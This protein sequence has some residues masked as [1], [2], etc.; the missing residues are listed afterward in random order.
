MAYEIERKFLLINE[1][2][3]DEVENSFTLR[4]GYLSTNPDATVRIR[5]KNEQ[6]TLTIKSKNIGIR[7]NEFEYQIPTEEAQQLLALCEGPLIQK[8]RYTIY[9]GSHTW[10]ID[11]FS[12]D[13]TGL[14]LAEIELTHEDD[15]FEKPTWVGD[16]VSGDV[17]YYNSNLVA[18]PFINW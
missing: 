1:Q 14:I 12:G 17:R 8:I 2:W 15:A 10:E 3:R 11:E 6:A 5:I 4:Q 13:N 16:E 9:S 7:R 18:H